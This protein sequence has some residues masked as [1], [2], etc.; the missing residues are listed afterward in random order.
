MILVV[1]AK[2]KELRK[3]RLEARVSPEFKSQLILASTIAGKS[4]T[5]FVVEHLGRAA[6]V[7][8]HE[9]TQWKLGQADS[10]AFVEALLDPKPPGQHLVQAVQRYRRLKES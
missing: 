3:E 5:D 10:E 6:Q 1:E 9:H 4:V 7:V 8:I 2:K